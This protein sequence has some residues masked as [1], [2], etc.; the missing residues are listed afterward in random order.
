VRP[1]SSFFTTYAPAC[2]CLACCLCCLNERC[3]SLSSLSHSLCLSVSLSLSLSLSHFRI[4][5][6]D[7][8]E[9]RRIAEKDTYGHN[10]VRGLSER[11]T[12]PNPLH[13][14]FCLSLSLPLC[15]CGA[16]RLSSKMGCFPTSASAS[17]T[18]TARLT[19]TD[20]GNCTY[21]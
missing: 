19:T 8:A 11:S 2:G 20:S 5:P 21:G 4:R 16:K 14:H 9:A 7:E 15:S 10:K 18:C 13:P 12:V 6:S 1:C 3:V 17:P